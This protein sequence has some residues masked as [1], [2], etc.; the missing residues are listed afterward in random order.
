MNVKVLVS[1]LETPF[2]EDIAYYT[3]YRAGERRRVKN[4]D[5]T[6]SPSHTYF[7]KC[8]VVHAYNSSTWETEAGGFLQFGL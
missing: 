1:G 6:S 5:H 2:S 4:F 8:V 7:F 3:V